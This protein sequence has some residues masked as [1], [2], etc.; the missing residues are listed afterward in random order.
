MNALFGTRAKFDLTH[1]V[2]AR[3]GSA[4]YLIE[5]YYSHILQLSS[6]KPGAWLD[7][8]EFL[9]DLRIFKDGREFQYS[10]LGDQGSIR[11]TTMVGSLDIV[12]T[13][14]EYFRV[15]GS[16]GLSLQLKA[17]RYRPTAKAAG[18]VHGICMLPDGSTELSC[19]TYGKLRFVPLKGS[20]SVSAPANEDGASF[21][22]LVI[23]LLPDENGELDFAVHEDMIELGQLPAAYPGIEELKAEG[24]A[25]YNEF[26]KNYLQPAKGFETLYRYA[27]HTTWARR[28][29]PGG[30]YQSPMIL[31]HY[32]YLGEA[33]S[34][35]QSFNAISMMGDPKEGWREICTMFEYQNELTGQ[36]PGNVGYLSA[37][38]GIQPPIQGFALDWLIQKCGDSFLTPSECERMLPKFDKWINFW[39]TTRSAGRGDDVTMINSPN[40]SGWDDATIFQ[41]GFPTVNPDLIAFMILLL[42][43]AG[44]LAR[45]CGKLAEAEAYDAR[46][47]KLLNTL[48]EEFWDGDKFVTFHN[49]KAV[50]SKSVACFQ[51]IILGKRL[52]QN[53]ID[54]VAEQLVEEGNFLCDIGLASESFYSTN[55]NYG[56]STFVHGRVV[57][58]VQLFMCTGL[59]LAGK[60]KEAAIIARR[61]CDHVQNM[62][63]ILGF[64]PRIDTYQAT[65]EPIYIQPGPVASDGWPWS[66]WCACSCITLITRII[67]EGEAEE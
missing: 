53:I 48:I 9:F 41:D 16:K 32:E 4:F 5:N 27:T 39:V 60:K 17:S 56:H 23:D 31:M 67:P 62:G 3:E 11:L 7:S 61:F 24:F 50:D 35:Q 65:G 18:S 36:L 52:P 49:G 12:F 38:K 10:Y 19:G 29:K 34:W 57:A 28:T 25:Q 42:E 66:S 26:I 59:N 21:A 64:P 14:H 44:R 55:C 47:K 46:S 63:C 6:Y 43:G 22:S 51:P 1:A 40:D 37:N 8:N 30:I 13:Y 45:G 20:V 15:A 54:R 58:P 33:F 2:Y